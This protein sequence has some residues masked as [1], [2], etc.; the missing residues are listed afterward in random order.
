MLVPKR[1]SVLSRVSQ[2]KIDVLVAM[3][4]FGLMSGVL[5]WTN[6]LTTGTIATAKSTAIGPAIDVSYGCGASSST[7][8]FTLETTYYPD[9]LACIVEGNGA[10]LNMSGGGLTWH[11]RGPTV[12][13]IV[14]GAEFYA[15][16]SSAWW[17]SLTATSSGTSVAT[18]CLAVSN[19][20]TTSPFDPHA[21]LPYTS[22][23][24]A[25]SEPSIEG[26]S[27]GHA[28]DMLVSLVAETGTGQTIP[29]AGFTLVSVGGNR[30]IAAY[31]SVSSIRSGLSETWGTP[32]PGWVMFADAIQGA[33]TS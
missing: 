14:Y 18:D 33:G 24:S 12:H 5:V 15:I 27:T 4:I 30:A 20:N 26:V 21:G 23:D 6:S 8:S 17:P 10:A 11:Q 3:I 7:C 29:P 2:T 25:S 28:N 19:V 1:M 22:G 31:S 32:V 13:H 16:T 9:I